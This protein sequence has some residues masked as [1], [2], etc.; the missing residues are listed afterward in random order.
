MSKSS[1]RRADLVFSYILMAIS[2]YVII[3]SVVIFFNPFAREWEK[4]KPETIKD[5]IEKWYESPALMPFLLGF[6]LLFLAFRLRGVALK[7]GAKFDFL[8]VSKIKTFV[9]LRETKVATFVIVAFF[10]YVLV[11]IP[12]CREYLNFFVM[13]Q[14]FP[15][16]VATFLFLALQMVVFNKKNLKVILMSLLVAAIFAG[17]ITYGFGTLALIPLP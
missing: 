17:A 2:V 6:I 4:I 8:S 12:L 5:T 9:N 3:E 15:F 1:L 13:F 10:V 14:G 16:L 11:F 7:A